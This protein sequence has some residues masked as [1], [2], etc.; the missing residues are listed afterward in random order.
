MNDINTLYYNNFGIAFQWKT[1]AAKDYQ[2]VQ[3]VFRNTGLLLTMGELVNFYKHTE[4]VLETP[5]LCKDCK[6][7]KNCR[8]LLLD[9]PISQIS[10]AMSY[11]ELLDIL[12]LIRGTLFQLGL[13]RMLEKNLIKKKE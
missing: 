6:D 5:R 1:C 4:K 13:D 8:S 12:D 10:F 3:L 9:T 7:D 2:K 11:T